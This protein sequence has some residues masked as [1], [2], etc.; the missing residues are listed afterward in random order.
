MVSR[1]WTRLRLLAPI[2]C[3]VPLACAFGQDVRPTTGRVTLRAVTREPLRADPGDGIAL[4]FTIENPGRDSARV[5]PRVH[6]PGGWTMPLGVPPVD[7]APGARATWLVA[8]GVPASAL[9]GRFI[10][11][12]AMAGDAADA[13][14]SVVVDV[15]KHPALEI[16][17]DDSPRWT[18]RGQSYDVRAIVKN[19]GNAPL[20]AAVSTASSAGGRAS[21]DHPR[22]PLNPGTSARIAIHVSPGRRS[23]LP[24]EELLSLVATDSV[25]TVSAATAARFPIVPASS[26]ESRSFSTMP[27]IVVV[28]QGAASSGVSPFAMEGAGRLP[29]ANATADFSIRTRASGLT[30]FTERDEYR[31]SFR[32]PHLSGRFGD[33]PFEL[34]PLTSSGMSGFGAELEAST[35]M[36]NV[37]TYAQTT[38]ATWP[39]MREVGAMVATSDERSLSG[40]LGGVI[41]AT[42]GDGVAHLGSA[43]ANGS[44][45]LGRV[46]AEAA[47]GDAGDALGSAGRLDIAG[48]NIG[49]PR[50]VAYQLEY[51]RGSTHYPGP[52][53]GSEHAGAQIGLYVAD[54]LLVSANLNERVWA[55]PPLF[56]SAVTRERWTTGGIGATFANRT[57]IEYDVAQRDL[58]APLSAA[59]GSQATLRATTGLT[60]RHASL[61][62]NVA[63]MATGWNHTGTDDIAYSY[64]TALSARFTRVGSTSLFVQRVDGCS[65]LGG[66]GMTSGGAAAQLFLPASL[67]FEGNVSMTQLQRSA[68]SSSVMQR[69]RWFAQG[70]ASV[71][72]TMSRGGR[73]AVVYRSWHNV[74]ATADRRPSVYVELRQPFGLP[75]GVLKRAGT[76]EGRIV[77][78][79]TGDGVAGALVRVG[80][81]AAISDR[82]GRVA[83]SNLS[84]GTHH[85]SVRPPGPA[86]SSVIVGR[87]ILDI[88]AHSDSPARFS[89]GVAPPAYVRVVVRLASDRDAPRGQEDS[90]ID[91][92]AAAAVRVALVG[93]RDT[94]VR[95]TDERGSIDF[96]GIAP[97]RWT[98]VGRAA[99]LPDQHAFEVEAFDF[100]VTPSERRTI[101]LRVVTKR[102]AVMFMGPEVIIGKPTAPWPP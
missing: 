46:S 4:S 84:V 28:R 8:I 74:F 9:A 60:F 53:R 5:L 39:M 25:A 7:V 32:S 3:G 58:A 91:S 64:G 48:D 15:S 77:D 17:V 55:P 67:D 21:V 86:A 41:R 40:S 16:F 61:T 102:K 51:S 24:D 79:T 85:I 65:L 98:L 90:L 59:D 31:A 10:V 78:A 43:S 33:Q 62:G 50:Q 73:L 14:D 22:L 45:G 83:F 12:V 54:G 75:T 18:T 95:T 82:D 29:F 97:G 70:Q 69:A 92:G 38:R 81:R 27:S 100:V 66:C 23:D 6:V 1:L 89:L 35:L 99:D 2:A 94:V 101:E 71:G 52:L 26:E 34:T 47:V 56:Q 68:E 93:G 42:A 19:V 13:V 87:P 11:R 57:T 76:A 36:G 96:G 20:V 37:T 72:R 49:G 80:D 30:P 88:S 44:F 63:R